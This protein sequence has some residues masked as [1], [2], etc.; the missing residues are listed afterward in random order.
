M[1][2]VADADIE[3]G[4]LVGIVQ[5]R[6][7]HHD[8]A[9]RHR[10]ELGDRRE[11]AGAADL[12]FDVAHDRGRLLGGEFVRDRPAR[13][14]RHE[15]EPLLP[16][17]AV[18]FVDHAVDVVIERGALHLDL[19]VKCQQL[20]DRPAHFGQRIGLEAARRKP[21]DHAGLRVGR[22][23]AHLAPRVGEE[24]KRPRRRDRRILL[25]QRAGRC[26]A[27]I[28]VERL[29]SF[30]L[31]AVEFEEGVLGH[32]DFAAHFTD[33]R[34]APAFELVRDVL[35]GF[36]VGGDIL[37]HAAVAARCAGDQHAVFVAQRHR[38]PVDLRLGGKDD[39]LVVLQAQE[40][41]DAADKIDDVFFGKRIVERQHRHRVP[42][43]G[44]PRGWRCADAPRQAFRRA[45]L[46][47]ARLDRVVALPQASY[48]A[49][50]TVG[51]SSW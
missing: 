15:A 8:A 45:Q 2:G 13:G 42:H 23:L 51:A 19:A 34:H 38:Q 24:A 16:I 1:H 26:V 48:S 46:R 12:N 17:E 22:H 44:E 50:E 37:A 20:L 41:A 30:G 35:Q 47:E 40:A 14:A 4:D 33:R 11:R 29:A 7:L 6:V 21:L 49:S 36:H 5:R 32:I 28:D 43:L 25:P 39:L 10:L 9:H 27:R 3:P 18:D 31:L